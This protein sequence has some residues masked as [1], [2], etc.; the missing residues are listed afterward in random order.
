MCFNDDIYYEVTYI[1]CPDRATLI[2]FVESAPKKLQDLVEIGEVVTYCE[3]GRIEDCGE[4]PQCV[5]PPITAFT[6]N[7]RMTATLWNQI[8]KEEGGKDE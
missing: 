1:A 6:R 4:E 8:L 7:E 2:K 3:H 5:E